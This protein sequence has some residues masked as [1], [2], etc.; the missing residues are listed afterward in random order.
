MIHPTALVHP[1]AQLGANV[2]V[3]PHAIVDA[4]VVVGDGT[5]IGPQVHLTGHLQIGRENRFHTGAVIGDAPQDLKYRNEPTRVVIGDRNVFREHVT[6]HRASKV[7]EDTVIG[8]D[9]LLMVGS[10]VG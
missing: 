3:G 6:V 2:Q 4:Q 1:Q 9:C 7:E 8:S 10:H 5:V